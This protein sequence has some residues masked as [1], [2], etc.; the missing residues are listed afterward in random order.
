VG[1]ISLVPIFAMAKWVE[2]VVLEMNV[3]SDLWHTSNNFH[4]FVPD[5]LHLK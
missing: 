1:P 4:I 2:S 3:V 5:L